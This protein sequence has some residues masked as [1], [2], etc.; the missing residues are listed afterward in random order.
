MVL[1]CFINFDLHS[2]RNAI[3]IIDKENADIA[4]CNNAIWIHQ[5]LLRKTQIH[6]S[7][8]FS[9]YPSRYKN[10]NA[11]ILNSFLPFGAL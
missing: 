11:G 9:A 3:F 4:S 8:F 1:I 6:I 2:S 7:P 10:A 5:P